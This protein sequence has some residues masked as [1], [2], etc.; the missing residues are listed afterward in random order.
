MEKK[1]HN[2][3]YPT[4][5]IELRKQNGI[6]ENTFSKRV[7]RGMDLHQAATQ[8]VKPIKSDAKFQKYV[9]IAQS[10]GI[11][12][13]TFKTR[14]QQLGWSY[15][16]ASTQPQKTSDRQKWIDKARQNGITYQAFR[17][18]LENGWSYERASTEPLRKSKR[19][20]AIYG[21]YKGDEFIT[22][23]TKDE[24]AKVLGVQPETI[25]FYSTSAY[26]KRIKKLGIREDN[27]IIAEKLGEEDV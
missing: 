20:R 26:R 8:P 2:Q 3:K 11:S 10:N 16:K 4:E 24:C 7:K 6:S 9:E 22:D 21:I 18:R 12:Y 17:I 5:I 13:S 1:W 25:Y 14:V 19:P 15:E 27:C 23:G